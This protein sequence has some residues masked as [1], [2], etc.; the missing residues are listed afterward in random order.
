[1]RRYGNHG[2]KVSWIVIRYGQY[3]RKVGWIVKWYWNYGRQISWIVEWFGKYEKKRKPNREKI[4][5]IGKHDNLNCE[6]I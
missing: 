6:Q 4:W 1:M 3:E 2:R 5:K